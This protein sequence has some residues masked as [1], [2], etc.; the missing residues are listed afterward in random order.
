VCTYDL[1]QMGAEKLCG[2]S[3]EGET[4]RSCADLEIKGIPPPNEPY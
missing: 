4:R 3:R 1:A 2:R